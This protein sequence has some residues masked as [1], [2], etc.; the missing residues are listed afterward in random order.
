MLR[1]P[2]CH[3]FAFKV[4]DSK[5]AAGDEHYPPKSLLTTRHYPFRPRL[6]KPWG[7]RG[8]VLVEA[9]LQHAPDNHLW[10]MAFRL[11][12]LGPIAGDEGSYF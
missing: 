11:K 3:N 9:A 10:K 8:Q 7:C 5:S 12:R 2:Q 1:S 6:R 4:L